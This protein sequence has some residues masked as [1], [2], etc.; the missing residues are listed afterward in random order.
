MERGGAICQ[1]RRGYADWI[2][3]NGLLQPTVFLQ[4]CKALAFFSLVL[5]CLGAEQHLLSL[6][7]R[8]CVLYSGT[9]SREVD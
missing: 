4:S 7:M 1:E 5:G 3:G 2:L 6:K 9:S 8:A